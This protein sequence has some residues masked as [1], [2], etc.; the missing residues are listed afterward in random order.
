M[1]KSWLNHYIRIAWKEKFYTLINHLGLAVGLASAIIIILFVDFHMS[2]DKHIPD[3][4]R[5]HKVYEIQKYSDGY[6]LYTYSTPYPL[7]Q[8]IGKTFPEIEAATHCIWISG[9]LG[10]GEKK[11]KENF[12]IAD[13]SFLDFFSIEMISGNRKTCL[14]EKYSIVLTEKM[15]KKLLGKTDVLGEIIQLNGKIPLKVTAVIKDFPDNTT[16]SSDIFLPIS[17]VTDFYGQDCVVWGWNA[18]NT[19]VKLKSNTNIANLEQ[20]IEADK[21][22]KMGESATT[23]HFFPLLKDH[24]TQPNPNESGFKTV[25]VMLSG[26]AFFILLIACINFVNLVTARS[27]NRAKE[28]GIRKVN[29]STR[30]ALIVQFFGESLL[31]ALFAL[32]IAILLVDLALP[33][34]NQIANSD[35][36][37]N[38][39]DWNLIQ[40]ILI[41]VVTVGFIS[42]IYPA[43]VLS[44]FSP[45]KVLKGDLRQGAR[46]KGFRK[47]M[48]IIQNTLTITLVI[49]TIFLFLQMNY[50]RNKD[51]GYSRKNLLMMSLDGDMGKRFTNFENDLNQIPEVAS[52][53]S[54]GHVPF[55]SGSST[56]AIGWPGKDTTQAYLFSYNYCSEGVV[57]SL[58][59][60]LLEGRSFLKQHPSD[61]TAIIINETAANIIGRKNIIGSQLTYGN[62]KITIIGIIKDFNYSSIEEKIGPQFFILHRSDSYPNW[63]CIKTTTEPNLKIQK[64][65]E[66]AFVKN[67]PEYPF[68]IT[69]AEELYSTY[70]RNFEHTKKLI[71]YL[72]FIGLFISSLGLLALASFMA[73][74]QSKAMILRKI[75]GASVMHLMWKL[76]VSFV[77]WILISACIAIPISYL[78]LH[79]LVENMAYYAPLSWWI[80]VAA[81]G[82]AL[83]VALGTVSYQ[84][85]KTARIN[86]ADKLRY[87]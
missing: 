44:S 64:K 85:F 84:A 34:F 87:E 10:S 3:S 47:S 9:V 2:F 12:I 68:Q 21:V 25:V 13:S 35:L 23:F 80:F 8:A 27:A 61:T 28:V 48:V 39:T 77:V 73:Q 15:A 71:T 69:Q 5:I 60:T 81:T 65:V 19:Y 16:V 36:H 78:L 6:S 74:Q 56:S 82:M 86:P 83:I 58:G 75:H 66:A 32:V 1:I 17:F 46:G 54:T 7:V 49:I 63:I 22:K 31:N 79:K 50:I 53:V 26:I 70:Y 51:L 43:L 42:G 14:L 45:T 59:L 72:C 41:L 18:Y 38:I 55:M 30:G 33:Y 11:L 4:E 37:F 52:V 57:E 76:C 62:E 20:K 24:L 40:K 67:Y 29:G